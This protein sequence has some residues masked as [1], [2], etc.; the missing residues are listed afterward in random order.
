MNEVPARAQSCPKCQNALVHIRRKGMML[1]V[2]SVCQGMWFD[3]GELTMLLEVYRSFEDLTPKATSYKC[4]R[5]QGALEELEFPGTSVT[6]DRCASCQAVFLD[7]G[8]FQVLRRELAAVVPKGHADLNKRAQELLTEVEIAGE[9]AFNCPKC[10]GKLWHLKRAGMI[11]ETCSQCQGMWF[12]AGELT[13]LLEVYKSF[14]ASEGRAVDVHCV[15]CGA[16][17]REMD[18]PGTEVVVDRCP[19]CQG[20]WLDKGEFETLQKHFSAFVPDDGKSYDERARELLLEAETARD[21]R[22]QC[23]R[24][25]GALH[26]T[27]RR[28]LPVETCKDCGGT[29]F[30]A[31]ELTVVLGVARRLKLS[32]GQRT[33]LSC[34]KCP[35]AKLVE[36]AY[37]R[38]EVLV[39]S[40][41]DC[42]AIWLDGGELEQLAKAC[43]VGL[44]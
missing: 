1:E 20:L 23:P 26:D 17:M 7:K 15:R 39:D 5:C 24:C 43:G 38:T 31:G 2:C 4:I 8:E 11:I 18:Y 16:Q 34:I 29:W 25:R 32:E 41:P 33:E 13:I 37:P 10:K 28:G 30:D 36:L 42:R 21:E 9:Q 44:N 40:C 3:A 14:E 35:N 22:S 6:I 19:D 27:R 12:D